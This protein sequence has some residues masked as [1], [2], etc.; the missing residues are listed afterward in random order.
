MNPKLAI[1]TFV[2]ED[3]RAMGNLAVLLTHNTRH[4]ASPSLQYMLLIMKAMVRMMHEV[5]GDVNIDVVLLML[6]FCCV[7][8]V[9]VL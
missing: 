7:S 9:I 1:R 5:G 8:V 4:V 2:A 3:W 6:L